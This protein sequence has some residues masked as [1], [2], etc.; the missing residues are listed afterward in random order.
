MTLGN[1]NANQKCCNGILKPTMVSMEPQRLVIPAF[2]GVSYACG[3]NYGCG[4]DCCNSSEGCQSCYNYA[5]LGSYD[6]PNQ[7]L[8]YRTHNYNIN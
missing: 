3:N 7:S 6:G 5:Q 8:C 2:G 1:Y 4:T